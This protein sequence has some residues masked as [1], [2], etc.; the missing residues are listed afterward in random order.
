MRAMP[1]WTMKDGFPHTKQKKRI[2]RFF[3]LLFFKRFCCDIELIQCEQ[4]D[5]HDFFHEKAYF[6]HAA[7]VKLGPFS[8]HGAPEF[9][10]AAFGFF[11]TF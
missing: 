1:F 10:I 11:D 4:I 2:S 8:F 5:R 9:R 3:L 6:L 7:G